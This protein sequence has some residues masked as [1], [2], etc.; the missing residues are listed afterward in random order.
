MVLE[1]AV[2]G[3]ALVLSPLAAEPLS[4]L[5]GGEEVHLVFRA[6]FVP[7][8]VFPVQGSEAKLPVVKSESSGSLLVQIASHGEDSCGCSLRL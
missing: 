1:S 2:D 3:P 7:T 4:L 5:L 6:H 8:S